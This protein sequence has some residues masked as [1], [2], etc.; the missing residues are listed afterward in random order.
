MTSRQK[1]LS[2]NNGII[3]IKFLLHLLTKKV[4]SHTEKPQTLHMNNANIVKI[5]M[6][7]NK[8]NYY[9][10][11]I[12][13]QEITQMQ[14][15]QHGLTYKEIYYKHIEEQ[16]NISSRTYRTYLGIPA[17]RELKKLQEAERLKGQQLTFNF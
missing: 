15:H 7:Y 6:A 10:K 16:F 3:K 17:K 13:I 4:R 11:I 12:K 5:C 1:Y 14:K 2:R 8:S 9:K